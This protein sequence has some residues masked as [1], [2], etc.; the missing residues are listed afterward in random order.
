MGEWYAVKDGGL[1]C[2]FGLGI[3]MQS[4]MY[5]EIGRQISYRVGVGIG[6]QSVPV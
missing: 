6:R 1:V 3:G 4:R 2:S 5:V